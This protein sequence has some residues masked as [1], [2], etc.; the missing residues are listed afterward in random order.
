MV[1]EFFWSDVMSIQLL[2]VVRSISV[3]AVATSAILTAL[4][5]PPATTFAQETSSQAIK[6]V[7]RQLAEMRRTIAYLRK[8]LASLRDNSAVVTQDVKD[9]KTTIG[10]ALS[11]QINQE[12]PTQ[13][14]IGK[15]T[16]TSSYVSYDFFEGRHGEAIVQHADTGVAIRFRVLE[17]A[18]A[19]QE[20]TLSFSFV[21]R[22]N[23]QKAA[24]AMMISSCLTHFH[25][26][27]DS[28]TGGTFFLNSSADSKTGLLCSS[29]IN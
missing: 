11:S 3:R 12:T 28:K 16:P 17:G 25:R 18:K 6:S 13:P 29:V 1:S 5:A 4:F 23:D 9:V 10:K 26:A 15:N 7:D 27:A 22:T 2:S 14:A 19:V 8:G 21:G 24:D 20:Y